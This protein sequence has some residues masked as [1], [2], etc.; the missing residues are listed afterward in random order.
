MI[1]LIVCFLRNTHLII[2]W[3][4]YG[5]TILASTRG[6]S[7][8]FVRISKGYESLLGRWA[9]TL[10]FTVTNA[11]A[12]QLRAP[13]YSIRSPIVT[14]HD[15]PAAVFRPIESAAE[16]VAFLSRLD[17]TKSYADQIMACKMRL[18]VSSTS[19]TPDEDFRLLLDTLVSYST[20]KSISPSLPS[21]LAII[22]GKGPQK[23]YYLDRIA[24]L[25]ASHQLT[26]VTIKTAWLSTEDY[27][28]LL[29]S[30]DLGV[31]LHKS[32][33]GVDL[34]MKVVDMFGAGLPVAGYS[35][36]ESWPELV[37]EGVNGRGFVTSEELKAILVELFDNVPKSKPKAWKPSAALEILRF[38]ALEEGRKRWDDEWDSVAGRMLGLCD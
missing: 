23:Q 13:P 7:H 15:R 26:N 27:A 34:P 36:Y 6:A 3:H 10:S 19:W 30:A 29:G 35:D 14:L 37:T 22:T 1:A 20:T 2:D 24:E 12:R 21:I 9:P 16:R 11:M 5:W 25:E 8:P 33:S 38:G 4:N 17:E 32:S 18:L 31:C 28:L